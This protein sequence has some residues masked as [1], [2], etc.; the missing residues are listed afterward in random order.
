MRLYQERLI[1]SI[2]SAEQRFGSAQQRN[3]TRTV[4]DAV[5]EA[6]VGRRNGIRIVQ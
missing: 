2:M 5:D 4:A 3:A 6:Q 1:W